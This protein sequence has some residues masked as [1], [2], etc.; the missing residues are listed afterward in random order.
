MQQYI[1]D[2]SNIIENDIYQMLAKPAQTV[3]S[4]FGYYCIKN[5]ANKIQLNEIQFNSLFI[6]M[7]LSLTL[8]EKFLIEYKQKY[9]ITI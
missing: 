7:P 8:M 4:G 2:D 3:A 1:L 6:K 5:L 9:D